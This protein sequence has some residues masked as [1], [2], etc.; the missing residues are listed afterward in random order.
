VE[1]VV[2][3][4]EVEDSGIGI[5]PDIL[6]RLFSAFEQADNTL[7]RKYG[8]TGLG[9]AITRKLAEHMGGMAGA[10]SEPGTGSTFW[11]TVRLKKG[12][13]AWDTTAASHLD[14]A[15]KRLMHDHS[16]R[17]VLLVEDE[18]INCEIAEQLLSEAG[19]NV[20]TAEDGQQAVDMVRQERYDLILMDIQMPMLDGLA[21]TRQIRALAHGQQV[22]IIAMTANAFAEDQANCLAAGMNDFIGKPVGPEHLFA[23]VLNWL[24]KDANESELSDEVGQRSD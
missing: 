6:P 3:R 16:G 19:L 13:H 21:A 5:A 20:H 10:T 8:G 7:T 17:R 4:F 22:P 18:P 2:L 14:A 11:F 24:D 23:T 15:E 1:A 12:Q 9:L